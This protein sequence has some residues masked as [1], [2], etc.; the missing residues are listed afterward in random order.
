MAQPERSEAMQYIQQAMHSGILG[1]TECWNFKICTHF[2][3]M[4]LLVITRMIII[5]RVPI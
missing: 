4:L 5:T 3:L 2:S 1:V